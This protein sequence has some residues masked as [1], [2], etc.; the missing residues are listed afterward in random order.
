M[1]TEYDFPISCSTATNCTV[2]TLRDESVGTIKD[3]M[4]DTTTGEVAYV[5]L[6]V[7]IGFLNLGSKLLALPWEAFDF[8]GH[9]RDVIIVNVSKEKLK[10]AP[11][12][13]T[14][15]WPLGPQNEFISNVH[16]YYGFDRKRA[17]IE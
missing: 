10:D 6:S 4:L 15:E 9:Q 16:S 13:E 7:D 12:F 1:N 11:G 3:L 17:L 2:K 14:D 5:V 8:H